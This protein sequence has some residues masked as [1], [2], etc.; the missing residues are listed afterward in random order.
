MRPTRATI[1]RMIRWQFSGVLAMAALAT[2]ACSDATAP[3]AA[4]LIVVSQDTVRLSQ[5]GG[6]SQPFITFRE[7][8]VPVG[9]SKVWVTGP[10]LETEV[11]PGKWQLLGGNPDNL[12]LQAVLGNA[13][14]PTNSELGAE[15]TMYFYVQPGRWRLRQLYQVTASSATQPSG[16]VF[17]ATS[18]VFVVVP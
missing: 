7:Q 16:E 3:Q 15:R 4:F 13:T 10:Y 2:A 5:G 1:G 14:A 17:A 9:Q 6:G 11:T 12:Y 8:F 18:N